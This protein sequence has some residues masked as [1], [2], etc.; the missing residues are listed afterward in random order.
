MMSII[1]F[2]L[3]VLVSSI[4]APMYREYYH[5]TVVD[6]EEIIFRNIAENAT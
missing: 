3:C 6:T 2:E 1:C 4:M 5:K